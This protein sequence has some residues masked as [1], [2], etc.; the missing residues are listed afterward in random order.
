MR[1]FRIPAHRLSPAVAV[2][3]AVATG[4]ATAFAASGRDGFS[5]G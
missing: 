5:W 1:A 3:V 4:T 2:A